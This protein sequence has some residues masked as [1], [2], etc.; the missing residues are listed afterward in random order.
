[1]E[2]TD[3]EVL[4]NMGMEVMGNMDTENTE[5]MG[6]MDMEVMGNME[7]TPNL[8]VSS[9]ELLASYFTRICLN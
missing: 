9:Q 6:N 8:N 5:V 1:M 2:N 3:T 4:G 7:A